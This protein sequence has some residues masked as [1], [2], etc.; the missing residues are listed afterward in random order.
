MKEHFIYIPNLTFTYESA[1]EPL[2]NS[3][4]LQFEKGWT[5]VV[6]PNGSGKTTLLK[7]IT[8]DLKPD[9]GTMTSSNSAIYCEQRPDEV[10]NF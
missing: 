4:S 9:S 10:P 2:F 5:G 7:I 3:I 1:I 6:G 8:G